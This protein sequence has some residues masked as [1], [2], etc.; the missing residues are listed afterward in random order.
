MNG[1]AESIAKIVDNLNS[2]KLDPKTEVV[3]APPS[4]YLLSTREKLRKDVEVAAQNVYFKPFGAY[5]GELAV[6]QVLDVGAN[7]AIIGHSER[8]TI[9]GESN[10]LISDKVKKCLEKNLGVILCIGEDLGQRE[11]N[12]TF[13]FVTSQLQAVVD[14]GVKDWSHIVIAYEPIWAIGTGKV[15]TPQQAQEVHAH[16][17]KWI[18]ATL[19]SGVANSTRI[20]YGGS[21]SAKN[22]KELACEPDIDGFLVGGA[23]LK[24]EF[25]DIVNAKSNL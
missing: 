3:V 7:W 18:E 8:R 13:T 16:I 14:S 11:R 5:T 1:T 20:I 22:A 15:A 10:E 6:E 24:P 21:V 2:A 4:V 17:R 25:S 12:E 9:L 19:G 23:S